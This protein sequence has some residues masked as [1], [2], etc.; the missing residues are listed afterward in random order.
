MTKLGRKRWLL[1]PLVVL[2][3]L[4][5]GWF[6]QTS[7]ARKERDQEVAALQALGAPTN[8]SE[9][10]SLAT[11]PPEDNAAPIYLKAFALLD[12]HG[13]QM[14]GPSSTGVWS[15]G[16]E[17]RVRKWVADNKETLEVLK[18]AAR[19]PSS[20]FEREW[21][22]G[23][24]VSFREF[25]DLKTC[26]KLVAKR[27][28]IEA[29]AG[30]FQAAMQWLEVGRTIARHAD[31]PI[32]IGMLVA[33]ACESIVL[34]EFQ[35]QLETYGQQASFRSVAAK[36]VNRE[37]PSPSLGRGLAGEVF[38]A[39]DALEMLG[40]GRISGDEF[41]QLATGEESESSFAGQLA[42]LSL[43]VPMVRYRVE[44][45]LLKRYR[46]ALE[47]IRAG[48]NSLASQTEAGRLLDVAVVGDR[49][50]TG[51][52]AEIFTPFFAQGGAAIV[53]LEAKRRMSRCAL[54]VWSQRAA[55]GRFPNA[56]PEGTDSA[57]PFT[58][59]PFVYQVDN[60]HVVMY[61]VGPNKKDEGGRRSSGNS[62]SDD[63]SYAP[64]LKR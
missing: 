36:F 42:G 32:L 2:L 44:T 49:S 3:P 27:A 57:D 24:N 8:A 38:F 17:A 18:Q 48:K 35:K 12:V 20:G 33:I 25:A 59:E 23:M 58:G 41:A 62:Q 26:A 4:V 31:E 29:G 50:L 47:A 52:L 16:D 5:V 22:E 54:E 51:R 11:V 40:N 43:R 60:G 14:P 9:M 15:A 28:E 37:T 53:A 34:A 13:K 1:A 56:L 46:L 45:K 63:L 61:S 55:A 10:R 19:K 30:R 7:S 39:R 21:E 64:T 6:W